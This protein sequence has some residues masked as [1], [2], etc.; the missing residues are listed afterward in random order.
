YW[1]YITHIFPNTKL[2][3]WVSHRQ[4]PS[5]LKL[6]F[7]CA[8]ALGILQLISEYAIRYTWVGTMLNGKRTREP[9][10]A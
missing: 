5:F 3:I 2:Q 8:L 7:I 6:L 4:Y 10:D 9:V 1:L